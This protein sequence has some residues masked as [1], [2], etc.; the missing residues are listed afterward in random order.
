MRFPSTLLTKSSGPVDRQATSS[1]LSFL[2][3]DLI[4]IPIE[5]APIAK[6]KG[7]KERK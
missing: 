5:V 2:R 6:E 7:V 3:F 1:T 4:R